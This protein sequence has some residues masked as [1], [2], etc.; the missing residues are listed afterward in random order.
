MYALIDSSIAETNDGASTVSREW[1][2][3]VILMYEGI[4][5]EID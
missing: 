1:V 4:A 5:S 2:P 3:S